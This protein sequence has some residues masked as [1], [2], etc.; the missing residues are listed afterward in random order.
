MKVTFKYLVDIAERRIH[1]IFKCETLNSF[2]IMYCQ[3]IHV[4][5]STQHCFK[6]IYM[7]NILS[8]QPTRRFTCEKIASIV[9]TA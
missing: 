7:H 6:K 8:V 9:K 2:M 3:K 4:S 5:E 1:N